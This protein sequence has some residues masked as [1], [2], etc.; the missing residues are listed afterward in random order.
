[1]GEW[2]RSSHWKI[3]WIIKDSQIVQICDSHTLT[4]GIYVH[5][6][7]GRMIHLSFYIALKLMFP[8]DIGGLSL[9]GTIKTEMGEGSIAVLSPT[10]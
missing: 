10:K 4:D 6:Y 8:W 7:V 1:M 3:K 5:H 9:D 2:D